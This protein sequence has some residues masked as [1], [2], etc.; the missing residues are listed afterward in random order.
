VGSHLGNAGLLNQYNAE[1]VLGQADWER[2][3]IGSLHRKLVSH[4]SVQGEKDRRGWEWYYLFSLCHPEERMLFKR[5]LSPFASWSPDGEYVAIAGTIW[6]ARTGE[7]VRSFSTSRIIRKRTSWSPDGQK[8]AWSMASDDSGIYIW[9]RSTDTVSNLRGHQSSVWCIA[10]SPD[11]SQLASG[12]IDKTLRIWDVN[13]RITVRTLPPG[14]IITGVAWSPDGDLLAAG[15]K[16]TGL[17][18]WKLST[19]KLI[20]ERAEPY[21][22]SAVSWRPDGEQLAVCT[23]K[24]WYLLDST[25]WTVF[26]E[27]KH[28][29]GSGGGD[30]WYPDGI[31]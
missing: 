28:T 22:Y 25:D 3:N 16:N 29:P 23:D 18:I 30:A 21:S 8:L 27:H 14:D 9:D 11:G 4:L 31:A 12:S 2:G 7:C 1:I 26:R 5:H 15:V 13:Q 20:V 6:R 24:S 17:K 10:W 19:G